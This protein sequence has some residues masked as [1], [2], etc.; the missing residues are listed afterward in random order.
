MEGGLPPE[1]PP[2]GQPK[3]RKKKGAAAAAGG[4]EGPKEEVRSLGSADLS[5]KM[6]LGSSRLCGCAGAEADQHLEP[7]GVPE[8]Q[9][10]CRADGEKPGGEARTLSASANLPAAE[11]GGWLGVLLSGLSAE[12]PGLR[13]VHR[14]G[15]DARH[16][17][18]P[19]AGEA[20][21]RARAR[22]TKSA[23]P[24]APAQPRSL[25]ERRLAQR[26]NPGLPNAGYVNYLVDPESSQ[27]YL[28]VRRPLPLAPPSLTACGVC[29]RL[30][31]RQMNANSRR[32]PAGAGAE[33]YGNEQYGYQQDSN[34][35][36]QQQLSAS[37]GAAAGAGAMSI[38]GFTPSEFMAGTPPD[39]KEPGVG[40]VGSVG[41]G[42][43]AGVAAGA[44]GALQGQQHAASLAAAHTAAMIAGAPGP[45]V[46]AP[47]PATG[48]DDEDEMMEDMEL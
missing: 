23:A 28:Q 2:A 36:A 13:G 4:A 10:Q 25:T 6:S 14:A 3:G 17:G 7:H 41:S 42:G 26:K 37:P 5:T 11:R 48:G 27:L 30:C 38:E 9:R 45:G 29:V 44:D 43:M 47:P 46:Q 22:S 39:W 24:L 19:G 20:P 32:R 21:A 35:A 8:N 15:R 31:A 12:A 1:P 18:H 16:E 34:Y 40:S 33:G